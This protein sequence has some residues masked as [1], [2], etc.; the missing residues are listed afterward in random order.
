M[1]KKKP[2]HER[3]AETMTIYEG[4]RRNR[5]PECEGIQEF[6]R[7]ANDFVRK[8]GT[9]D[10]AVEISGGYTAEYLLTDR[11]GEESFLRVKADRGDGDGGPDP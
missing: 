10:K 3:L 11:A 8:G 7:D 5:V 4:L 6:Q 9:T 1:P 2:V